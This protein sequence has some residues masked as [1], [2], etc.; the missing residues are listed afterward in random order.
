MAS[1]VGSLAL[2]KYYT[3]ADYK[4]WKLAEGERYELIYGKAYPMF[5]P[6]KNHLSI[7]TYHQLI[8]MELSRQIAN[9]LTGKPYKVFPSP[10]DVRLFYKESESDDTVVQPDVSIICD[11][12]KIGHEGGRGAPDFIA[13]ILSFSNTASEMLEK[14]ELY[15]SAGVREYWVLDPETK[16]LYVYNFQDDVIFPHTYQC[17]ESAKVGIFSDLEIALEPVFAELPT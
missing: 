15:R 3:Y 17:T 14:F 5:A 9:Y 4:K 13:E 1:T 8:Q 7:N 2:D 12:K 10:F 11:K 6:N 16:T